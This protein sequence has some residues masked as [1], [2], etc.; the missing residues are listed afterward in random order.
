MRSR[1]VGRQRSVRSQVACNAI[2]EPD[3]TTRP[4][5]RADRCGNSTVISSAASTRHDQLQS[6]L[7][8]AEGNVNRL[9]LIKRAMFGRANFDLLRLRVLHQT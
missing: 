7:V 4:T 8:L 5:R 6:G 9:K 2:N 1:T 3:R